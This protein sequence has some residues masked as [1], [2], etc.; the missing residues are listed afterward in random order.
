MRRLGWVRRAEHQKLLVQY[1]K[2]L[3]DHE[4]MIRLAQALLRQTGG[5]EPSTVEPSRDGRTSAAKL[6]RLH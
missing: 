2:L 1:V 6:A 3:D 5:A 4:H